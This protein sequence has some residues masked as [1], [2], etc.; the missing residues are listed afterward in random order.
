MTIPT[1]QCESAHQLKCQ[2]PHFEHLLD[3]RRRFD[4][5]KNDRDFKVGDVIKFREFVPKMQAAQFGQDDEYY[6][7]RNLFMRVR[8]ILNPRPDHD[9]D[10][11]LAPDF[12]AL[13]LEPVHLAET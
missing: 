8:Y 11:G 2:P 3:G 12:I 10:F 1:V 4:V 9:P 5:R 13:D 7:G 6:T